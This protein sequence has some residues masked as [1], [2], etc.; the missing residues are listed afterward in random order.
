[1]SRHIPDKR[2]RAFT[3]GDVGDEEAMRIAMHLDECPHCA[4]RTVALEPLS[5]AFAA[6]AEPEVPAGLI[7]Q[8]VYATAQDH[9]RRIPVFELAIGAGLLAAACALVLLGSDPIGV[10]VQ[11]LSAL[12]HVSQWIAQASVSIG[13]LALASALFIVG[14][15]VALRYSTRS[16]S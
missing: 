12:P 15:S 3:L 2:L 9:R 6:V 8:I 5:L 11:S 13:A 7:E 16:S 14:S 1:M 10:I 4:E